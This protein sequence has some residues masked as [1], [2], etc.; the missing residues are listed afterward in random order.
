MKPDFTDEELYL[1]ERLMD[2]QYSQLDTKAINI[3]E[4]LTHAN[5]TRD[6]TAS[7]IPIE[8]SEMGNDYLLRLF[9]AARQHRAV[10]KKCEAY[11]KATAPE[12]TP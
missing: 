10:S 3:M 1:I 4:V 9:D 11:R 8:A 5:V 12:V 6:K 7:N 2:I